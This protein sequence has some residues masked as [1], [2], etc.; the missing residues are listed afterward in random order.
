M[1]INLILLK[2]GKYTTKPENLEGMGM[3]QG[4]INVISQSDKL[5]LD[6]FWPRFYAFYG[7]FHIPQITLP[8]GH[9]IQDSTFTKFSYTY[10]I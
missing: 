6:Q 7:Q 1:I 2:E 4:V 9:R 5:K 10:D 8:T 3:G